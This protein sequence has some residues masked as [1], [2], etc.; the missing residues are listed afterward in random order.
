MAA[1][2]WRNVNGPDLASAL[3]GFYGATDTINSGFSGLQKAFSTYQGD[4][5]QLFTDT[6]EANTQ[7][8]LNQLA[9]YRT[10]EEL[11]AAQASG[12]L[13]KLQ[14][15]FGNAID[16]AQV[17]G[18]TENRINVLRDQVLKGQQYDQQQLATKW[19]PVADQLTALA[20]SDDPDVRKSAWEAV[21]IYGNNGMPNVG[22]LQAEF[23]KAN[24]GILDFGFKAED[25]ERKAEL[26]PLE[27]Q[28]IEAAT[29]AQ[30]ESIE[31]SRVARSNAAL[32][33]DLAKLNLTNAQNEAAAR[34]AF[35]QA[36]L[37]SEG[38]TSVGGIPVD[39]ARVKALT[40]YL[41]T[42]SP[43]AKS[44][45]LQLAKAADGEQFKAWKTHED[46][47]GFVGS[48]SLNPT[49]VINAVAADI[50]KI[51]IGNPG[52]VRASIA[53]KVRDG[54]KLP[55]TVTFSDGTQLPKGFTIPIPVNVVRS[56]LAESDTNVVGLNRGGDA[57]SIIE[58]Y[59]ARP[60]V[61]Q[62]IL[63]RMKADLSANLYPENYGVGQKTKK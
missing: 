57:T 55:N 41:E 42:L 31:A 33:G 19:N 50:D 34:K 4:Q 56:A 38:N 7:S 16:Q 26:H 3:R 54:Y 5:R 13:D 35:S 47:N 30:R 10:P 58:K 51:T 37:D 17:R 1:I 28:R 20:A 52:E 36:V 39:N 61:Q 21:A 8:F 63:M 25:A 11:A 40:P 18:A 9:Q 22:R 29:A 2:T 23:T 62:A 48:T 12:E 43:E 6:K 27:K 60:E 49:N 32:Q 15:S 46:A 24:Q 59:M 44:L 14:A 45:A 53:E